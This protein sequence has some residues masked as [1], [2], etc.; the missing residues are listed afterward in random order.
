MK[1]W[2]TVIKPKIS[3]HFSKKTTFWYI[4]LKRK[5]LLFH[6][7]LKIKSYTRSW[8]SIHRVVA[9]LFIG[10]MNLIWRSLHGTSWWLDTADNVLTPTDLKNDS[11]HNLLSVLIR[12]VFWTPQLLW[13]LLET[14][15]ISARWSNSI[16]SKH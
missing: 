12:I 15:V 14:Y 6:F 4:D 5:L 3:L 10:L 16:P 1:F 2:R 9:C 13:G 7:E 8:K 11:D